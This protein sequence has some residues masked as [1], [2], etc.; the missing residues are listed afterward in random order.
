MV[1]YLILIVLIFQFACKEKN[2]S[3]SVKEIPQ[4]SVLI[5]SKS[6]RED[7]LGCLHLRDPRKIVRIIEQTKLIGKDSTSVKEYLGTPNRVSFLKD[8]KYYTYWLEC[9]GEKKI[10]YSNFYCY[11]RGDTLYSYRHSI[12]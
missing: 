1:R 11:F 10:S 4:D 3:L 2:Q 5:I 8:E 9:V 12:Y 7:S 6:W